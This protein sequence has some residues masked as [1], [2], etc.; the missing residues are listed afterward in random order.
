M[1]RTANIQERPGRYRRPVPPGPDGRTG[2]G[3]SVI[4]GPAHAAP[5]PESLSVSAAKRALFA[6]DSY[7]RDSWEDLCE[8]PADDVDRILRHHA[9]LLLKPDAVVGRRLETAAGWLA[10][11]G[12]VVAAERVRL[13]RHTIRAMW[14]YQWNVASRDRRDLADLLCH[15]DG[16]SLLLVV[17]MPPDTRPA[18]ARLSA[19]KGPADPAR[20]T[21]GQ[22]RHLLGNENFLLNFVHA[23]DEPADLVREIGVLFD[24]PERRRLYRQLRRGADATAAVE[25]AVRDL[26]ERTPARDLTL[27]GLLSRQYRRLDGR[28]GPAVRELAAALSATDAG[29]NADWRGLCA[30]A[31]RAG[32]PFDAWDRVVLGTHLMVASEP[33]T[34][35][36]LGAAPPTS[37]PLPAV[38]PGPAVPALRFDQPVP[39][40]LV[41]KAGIDE[42]LVTD[43]APGAG[44]TFVLAGELPLTHCYL[45]DVTAAGIRY[46]VMALLELA[47]QA[48]Y[49]VTHRHLGVPLDRPFLLRRLGVDLAPGVAVAEQ[50]DRLR[51]VTRYAVERLYESA[52]PGLVGRL[53]FTTTD[54][55][56]IGTAVASFS[57]GPVAA[58]ERMRAEARAAHGLGPRIGPPPAGG[59]PLLPAVSVG[60]VAPRN[61]LLA[62]FTD[63]DDGGFGVD[64]TV[65]V[66]YRGL[67]DHPHDHLP[68]MVL[69]EAARQAAVR[70]AARDLAGVA[71]S[72]VL[73]ALD[74]SFVAVAE[75][76]LPVRCVG[77]AVRAGATGS[78]I[79]MSMRQNDTE[80]SSIVATV[81]ADGVEEGR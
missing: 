26:Y 55:R 6:V 50:P 48:S 57:W 66:A 40:R 14:Q 8:L 2:T 68:G 79:R 35:P 69:I 74:A 63:A 36:I 42:V 77:R 1:V 65:D 47:R 39:Y 73:A 58:Y 22:L 53:A 45:N 3:A 54:G 15:G 5:V 28:R 21:P 43:C 46:D 32:A 30:L 24:A 4:L 70:A 19:A 64:L 13:D 25:T 9:L 18:T 78:E 80:V 44:D 60:R 62:G 56:P 71:G 75:V 38:P 72:P 20:R 51:V 41:H 17:R 7:F 34:V 76:D 27:S 52:R 37:A 10:R 33:G 29:L 23:A 61:V 67:F 59:A 12:T 81:L 49:V 11:Q 31:E 16:D